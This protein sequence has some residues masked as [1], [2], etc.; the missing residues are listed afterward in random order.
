MALHLDPPSQ[1]Y[2][3]RPTIEVK[4]IEELF[5]YAVLVDFVLE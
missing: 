2:R 1:S 4:E 5:E 3:E